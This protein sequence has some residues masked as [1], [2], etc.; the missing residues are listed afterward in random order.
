MKFPPTSPNNGRPI[1]VLLFCV[2]FYTRA[3]QARSELRC[4]T[5]MN[6]AFQ[7]LPAQP[8]NTTGECQSIKTPNTISVNIGDLDRGCEVTVY[9]DL[10]CGEKVPQL[11]LNIGDC[12]N[13]NGTLIR[14][15]SVD[16]CPPGTPNYT[17]PPSNTTIT[18]VPSPTAGSSRSGGPNRMAIIGGAVGGGV[19]LFMIIAVLIGW[20]LYRR[21]KNKKK[22]RRERSWLDIP[23]GPGGYTGG[24]GGPV[25]GPNSYS[26]GGYTE[27]PIGPPPGE[28]E[29]NVGNSYF[30]EQRTVYKR[31]AAGGSAPRPGRFENQ[32]A[33]LD[34][35]PLREIPRQE[36]E[37]PVPLQPASRQHSR[38]FSLSRDRERLP[39][40]PRLPGPGQ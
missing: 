18:P 22:K 39:E 36:L 27:P 34:I 10:N 29:A 31:T 20:F 33:D 19:A 1:L 21:S 40:M 12:G 30:K 23:G 25:W 13:L 32:V 2:L 5:D 4:F 38:T 16:L 7:P 35:V 3:A 26:P 8:G 9:A 15:F 37:A 11:E 28:L 6:C 17:D 14:S 24:P